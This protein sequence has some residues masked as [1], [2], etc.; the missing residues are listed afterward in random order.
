MKFDISRENLQAELAAIGVARDKRGNI[1]AHKGILFE[2]EDGLLTLTASNPEYS[3]TKTLNLN[4][5]YYDENFRFVADGEFV[6]I[7]NKLD[8]DNIT[9][10]LLD[11]NAIEITSGKFKCKQSVVPSE[12]YITKKINGECI[13]VQKLKA[14]LL[15]DMIKSVIHACATMEYGIDMVRTGIKLKAANGKIEVVALDGNRIA[16]ATGEYDGDIDIIISGKML[17]EAMKLISG[18]IEIKQYSNSYVIES[19]G[20]I[21]AVSALEGTYPDWKRIA[22]QK[23]NGAFE[24]DRI[25]I[26]RAVERLKAIANGEKK[27]LIFETCK[28]KLEI[29]LKTRNNSGVEK[30]DIETDGKSSDIRIGLYY[31]YVIDALKSIQDNDVVIRYGSEAMPVVISNKSNDRIHIVMPVKI[32]KEA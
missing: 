28:G 10:E 29:S 16:V 20:Y 1:E 14:E 26:L 6:E 27:P 25:Q 2:I 24:V 19:N 7:A 11:G 21:I 12:Q 15:G 30:I 4:M 3:I 32:S 31:T 13:G 8:G 17:K 5:G 9:I 18:D 22:P 23:F